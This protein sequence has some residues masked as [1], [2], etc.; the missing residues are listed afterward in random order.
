MLFLTRLVLII[1][2]P[3]SGETQFK[4]GEINKGS[5][6]SCEIPWSARLWEK[7][8]KKKHARTLNI[9]HIW[10]R[11]DFDR[12]R[13]VLK[14]ALKDGYR[15]H[16]N[17]YVWYIINRTRAWI[18]CSVCD[19]HV[20]HKDLCIDYFWVLFILDRIEK[21]KLKKREMWFAREELDIKWQVFHFQA[22]SGQRQ[23]AC[24]VISLLLSG[25]FLLLLK[26]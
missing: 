18:H 2:I 22:Q 8:K 9:L 6:L 16:K 25:I 20:D 26:N 11:L 7:K 5:K 13:H 1:W 15:W 24:G 23:T 21:T 4:K 3:S 19:I 14:T 17:R 12:P 10:F